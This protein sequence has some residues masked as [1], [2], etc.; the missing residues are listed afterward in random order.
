[1]NK[2]ISDTDNYISNEIQ[3]IKSFRNYTWEKEGTSILNNPSKLTFSTNEKK[4]LN[5]LLLEEIPSHLRKNFWLISSRARELMLTNKNYY[6]NLL[7]VYDIL[8]KNKHPFYTSLERKITIDLERSFGRGVK[9]TEDQSKKLKNVLR[10]FCIRNATL[11]YAQGFNNIVVHFLKV[12]NFNEEETFYLFLKLMEDILPYDYYHF[13]IGIEVDN[14]MIL[15]LLKKYETNLYNHLCSFKAVCLL[16]TNTSMWLISMFISKMDVKVT[17]LFYDCL[18]FNPHNSIF[19]LY[20]F[21]ISIFKIL[22]PELMKSSNIEEAN[23]VFDRIQKGITNEEFNKIIYYI[24]IDPHRLQFFDEN[25]KN[26]RVSRIKKILCTKFTCFYFK[27][28]NDVKCNV[29]YP[30]C[31]KEKCIKKPI[32]KFIVYKSGY[33]LNENL[34]ED[35][36]YNKENNNSKENGYSE[37]STNEEDDSNVINE[38]KDN[39][40]NNIVNENNNIINENNNFVNENNNVVNDNNN[41]INENNNVVNENKNNENKSDENIVNN[42]ICNE[43]EEEILKNIIIERR[44]HLCQN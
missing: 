34:I 14:L 24:F 27:S 36:Y 28:I 22:K 25:V 39:E 1:M 6:K 32:E 26:S 41:I 4:T 31:V 44:G 30:V 3:K 35:F 23:I 8:I 37:K 16:N 15:A 17:N 33:N 42:N 38:N 19:I 40:N 12:T 9:P 11:N 13:S 43:D 5:L 7:K 21:I 2:K 20:S 18:F 29:N 10:A